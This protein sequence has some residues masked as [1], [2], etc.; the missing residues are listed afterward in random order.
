MKSLIFT[1]TENKGMVKMGFNDVRKIFDSLLSKGY[2]VI[3]VLNMP[4]FVG[5]V[6]WNF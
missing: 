5:G 1:A 6:E 4:L 2:T 3:D